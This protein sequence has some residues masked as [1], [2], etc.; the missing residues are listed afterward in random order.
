MSRDLLQ[1]LTRLREVGNFV[2]PEEAEI[3]VF[4]TATTSISLDPS[5]VH[6]TNINQSSLDNLLCS[7]GYS[8]RIYFLHQENSWSPLGVTEGMLQSIMQRHGI[9]LDFLDVISCFKPQG[10]TMDQGYS[11]PIRQIR[12]DHGF[13]IAFGCKFAEKRTTSDNDE[14]WTIRQLGMYHQYDE[15]AQSSVV[16]IL[17]PR[18]NSKILDAIKQSLQ[19]WA[20]KKESLQCPKSMHRII[21]DHSFRSW[22]EYMQFHDLKISKHFSDLV[23]VSDDLPPDHV[24]F[25]QIA[26]LRYIEEELL[27]LRP[28]FDH[29]AR[30][31]KCLKDLKISQDVAGSNFMTCD[32][33][34]EIAMENYEHQLS[35]FKDDAEL[36]RAKITSVLQLLSDTLIF[37][38]QNLV[39]E[40][41]QSSVKDSAAV[42]VITILTLIYLP[43]TAV[44]VNHIGYAI[45]LRRF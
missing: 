9:H 28:I 12:H 44:A 23:V 2:S 27:P 33:Q 18:P 31:F 29:L 15:V 5:C 37:K 22:L 30:V 21:F 40:L 3:S 38:Q 6:H 11:A 24:K 7:I 45:L 14:S 25:E 8:M 1:L 19:S 20:S 36:L 39:L 16:L 32:S 4:D 42:R 26:D 41:T 34:F 10:E 13:E 43:A 17:C 35:N